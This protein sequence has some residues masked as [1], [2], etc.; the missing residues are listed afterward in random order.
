MAEAAKIRALTARLAKLREQ[1]EVI[2]ARYLARIK[3]L[4]DQLVAVA[5]EKDLLIRQRDEELA[6]LEAELKAVG[7]AA[8]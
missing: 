1:R 6:E 5:D 8:S 4:R 3:K 7:A 2:V